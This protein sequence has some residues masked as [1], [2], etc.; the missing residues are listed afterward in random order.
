LERFV[1]A[2]DQ[3]EFY[4]EIECLVE[5]SWPE[6]Q[7]QHPSDNPLDLLKFVAGET[8]SVVRRD[9]Y[10]L[11]TSPCASLALITAHFKGFRMD[12]TF[13]FVSVDST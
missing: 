11:R 10:P 9:F 6:V 7:Q 4:L 2:D 5:W 8:A 3:E 12:S 13:S 1:L